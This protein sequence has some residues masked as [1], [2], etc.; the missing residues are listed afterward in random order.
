MTSQVDRVQTRT[1]LMLTR[2]SFQVSSFVIFSTNQTDKYPS[3]TS[4]TTSSTSSTI[5]TSSAARKMNWLI[6]LGVFLLLVLLVCFARRFCRL[7]S[8]TSSTLPSREPP[9]SS[10]LQSPNS[11]PHYMYVPAPAGHQAMGPGGSIWVPEPSSSWQPAAT[12]QGIWAG[13]NQSNQGWAQNQNQSNPGF[14]TAPSMAEFGD[15][16]PT[17]DEAIV[18]TSQELGVSYKQGLK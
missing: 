6:Y 12:Q 2:Q 11:N 14:P 3:S 8:S 5:S 1:Q 4:S 15:L 13:Q 18:A 10:L 16:P 7:R 17:Y 9:S